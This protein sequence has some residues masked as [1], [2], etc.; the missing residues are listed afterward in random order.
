[1]S[2][3][4]MMTLDVR[5]VRQRSPWLDLKILLFTVPALLGRFNMDL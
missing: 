3:N 4:A 2:A 5:Y 1:V